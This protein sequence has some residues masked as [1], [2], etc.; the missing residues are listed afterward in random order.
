MPTS[1]AQLRSAING[2]P[3]ELALKID[4]RDHTSLKPLGRRART[5]SARQR[6][7]IA[8]SISRFSFLVPILIDADDRVLA[9]HGRLEAAG[10]L[11]LA[12][13]P[14]V[15]VSH[16][17][18]AEKRAYVLADNRLAELG[19]WDKR[20]LAAELKEL[21]TL[22][23]DFDLTLTG[24]AEVEIDAIVFGVEAGAPE[25]RPPARA[26][27]PVSR[28]GDLWRLGR[29][30]ILCADA[31]QAS[32]YARLTGEERARAVFTDPPYNCSI[33]G[34]VT[35]NTEH[36]EFP[37]AIGEMDRAAFAAFLTSALARLV[38]SARK[39]RW[40]TPRWIGATPARSA[41]PARPRS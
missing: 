8:A 25:E 37:M 12:T 31:T 20:I 17:T 14:V 2:V 4:Y 5:Y 24:F 39:V 40:S 41:R 16:L 27:A 9:G 22:D 28:I 13:V 3:P 33:K 1:P 11:G 18:A 26:S 34:H 7:A 36:R 10:A 29:H 19:G 15:V 30:R 38:T 21:R 6:E 32:S 35:S 23:L